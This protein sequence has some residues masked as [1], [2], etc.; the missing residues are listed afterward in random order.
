MSQNNQFYA[1]LA[2][3]FGGFLGACA[4]YLISL[5]PFSGH[6]PVTTLLTNFLGAIIIGMITGIVL[7]GS[8]SSPYLILFLKTG[9]CGGFTTFSTF[10]LESL[11]LL[12][13]GKLKTAILYML[14]SLLLCL[15]GVWAGK[16]IT[17]HFFFITR[18]K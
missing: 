12:E 18:L 16:N 7:A 1:L 8:I 10:S 17:E 3:G 13:Q 11:T 4:R 6:F 14:S 2:V 5:L 15:L 9:I